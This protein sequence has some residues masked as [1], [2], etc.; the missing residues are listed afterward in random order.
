MANVNYFFLKKKL[1]KKCLIKKR[2]LH[3]SHHYESNQPNHRVIIK[4]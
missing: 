2:L 4:E 3:L 1:S